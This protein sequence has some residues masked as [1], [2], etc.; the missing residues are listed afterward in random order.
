MSSDEM[1]LRVLYEIRDGIRS[2]NERVDATNARLDVMNTK[3]E[4]HL[5]RVDER[6]ERLEGR[7]ERVGAQI[8]ESEIRTATAINETSFTLQQIYKAIKDR[9][10]EIDEIKRRLD[11]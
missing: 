7:T 5:S 4:Q 6:L 10:R 2:T 11:E 8:V 3:V 9:N 1:T